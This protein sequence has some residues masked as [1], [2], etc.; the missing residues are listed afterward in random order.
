[1]SE[2]RDFKESCLVVLGRLERVGVRYH[3][4]VKSLR[5]KQIKMMSG[6]GMCRMKEGDVV[7]AALSTLLV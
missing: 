7:V 4:G 5:D 3:I 2:R 1:M 6:D